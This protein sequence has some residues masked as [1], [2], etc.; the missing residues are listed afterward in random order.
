M[1]HC[2]ASYAPLINSDTC[3]IYSLVYEEK[4]YTIEFRLNKN[5]YWVRQLYGICDS[6]AP[7]EVWNYVTDILNNKTNSKIA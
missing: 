5:R 3:A 2:V 1:H 4:R 7:K 6:Q